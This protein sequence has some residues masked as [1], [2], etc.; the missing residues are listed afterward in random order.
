M[1][2]PRLEPLP[3]RKSWPLLL[4]KGAIAF[5]LSTL[6]TPRLVQALGLSKSEARGR[7]E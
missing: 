4:G 3:L 1:N 2:R 6:L 5:V 7:A